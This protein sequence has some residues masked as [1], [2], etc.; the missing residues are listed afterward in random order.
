MAVA[1]R[2]VNTDTVQED[3]VSVQQELFRSLLQTPHRQ[4]DATLFLHKDQMERDPEFYARLAVYALNGG[5]D[6]RDINEA[7]VANLFN[8]EFEEIREVGYVLLQSLPPYQVAR[9]SRQFTGWHEIVHHHSTDNA[10]PTNGENGVTYERAKYSNKH[11]D[12][13]KRGKEIPRTEISLG[14]TSKLRERLLKV[15]KINHNT[16][17]IYKETYSVRHQGLGNRRHKGMLK[18]AIETYLR[19]R[20]VPERS[21][22]MEGALIR[23]KDD[24]RRLYAKNNRLPQKDASGWI[25]QWLFHNKAQEGTRLA[26]LQQLSREE[27]PTKQAEIIFDNKLPF[28]SVV[29]LVNN[30]TPAVWVALIEAMSS[31][32]LLQSLNQMKRHGVYDNAD[33]KKQIEAKLKKAKTSTGRMDALK[34]EKA[35][36]EANIS[37]DIKKELIDI[38]DTQ[39]SQKGNIKAKTAILI[40]KS[41]SMSKAIEIGKIIASTLS[42]ACIETPEVYLFDYGSKRISWTERD[43]DP[44]K[45]SNWDNKL[46]MVKAGGGTTPHKV[47]HDMIRADVSVEQMVIITDEGENDVGKF[48]NDMNL[49]KDHF[50]FMPNIVIVRVPSNWGK[51][52]DRMER[53]LKQRHLDVDVLDIPD[54]S[55]RAVSSALPNLVRMLS[56]KSVFDFVQEIQDIELPTRAEWD[57][58]N[59][60]SELPK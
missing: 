35:A 3:A 33:L 13:D 45:K 1:N 39:M 16:K 23:A 28:P 5:N 25:N 24:M 27:D 17:Q 11:A 43:G 22:Q 54:A 47:I 6:I 46:K 40:D 52:D 59:N 14:K 2:N 44:G 9:I 20:E 7:F 41:A 12:L 55:E 30:F 19:L 29:S 21:R 36:K 60:V 15:G 4:V 26:A 18:N 31:Q 8:S 49:Y 53:S 32:E 51:N 38:S 48:A 10:M 57:A 34:A 42:Q 56:K 37:D 58:K 50:G